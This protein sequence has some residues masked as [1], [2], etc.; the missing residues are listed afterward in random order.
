[1]YKY[2]DE[3]WHNK[4]T[5]AQVYAPVHF[6]LKIGIHMPLSYIK[7]C[8]FKNTSYLSSKGDLEKKECFV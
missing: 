6:L 8:L 5:S 4:S 7:Q 1:M 2:K 3:Y